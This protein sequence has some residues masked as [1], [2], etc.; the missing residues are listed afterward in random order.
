VDCSRRGKKPEAV[1]LD[2]GGGKGSRE[3]KEKTEEKEWKKERKKAEK[4]TNKDLYAQGRY[5]FRKTAALGTKRGVEVV[6]GSPIL[7]EKT[8]KG[9]ENGRR[10]VQKRRSCTNKTICAN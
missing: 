4:Q 9:E 3:V 2:A 10:R 1:R 6:R 7:R 8:V 5:A